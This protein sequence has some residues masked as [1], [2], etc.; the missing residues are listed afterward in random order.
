MQKHSSQ[1]SFAALQIPE[2]RYFIGSTA[3]F[4]LANR[5]MTVIIGFQIYRLTHSALALGILGLIEA[6]PA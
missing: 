4:T 6:I 1:Y 2:I 5:A 3:F